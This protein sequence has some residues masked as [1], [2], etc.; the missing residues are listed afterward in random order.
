MRF[1]FVNRIA[2]RHL[3]AMTSEGPRIVNSLD[4]VIYRNLVATLVKLL[5]DNPPVGQALAR[6]ALVEA[7]DWCETIATD[8]RKLFYNRDFIGGLSRRALLTLLTDFA[9]TEPVSERDKV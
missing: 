2:R 7:P 3:Q 9:A 4:D 5:F 1:Q 8:G 6:F